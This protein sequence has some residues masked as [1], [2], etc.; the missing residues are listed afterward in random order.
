MSSQHFTEILLR[1][2][3]WALQND[4]LTADPGGDHC[5]G[6]TPLLWAMS[7]SFAVLAV[8]INCL[9]TLKSASG[10]HKGFGYYTVNS[11]IILTV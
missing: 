3:H 11:F 5:P 10:Q 1:F 2:S 4:A 9:S 7:P 6:I 8:K